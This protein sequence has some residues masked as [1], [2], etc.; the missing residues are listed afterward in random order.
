MEP[1]RDDYDETENVGDSNLFY[2]DTKMIRCEQF[3]VS[4]SLSYLFS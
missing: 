4:R 2:N 1:E 3:A